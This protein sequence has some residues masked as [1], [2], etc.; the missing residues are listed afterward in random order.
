MILRRHYKQLSYS[1]TPTVQNGLDEGNQSSK[2]G[3]VGRDFLNTYSLLLKMPLELKPDK[4]LSTEWQIPKN[5]SPRGGGRGRTSY[6]A[7]W[8]PNIANLIGITVQYEVSGLINDEHSYLAKWQ[9]NIANL[10]GITVQYEVS[11]L[12][13]D[14]HGRTH[15]ETDTYCFTHSPQPAVAA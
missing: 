6:L 1:F 14:E 15:V 3:G 7:K 9:P 13:N 4:R 12:I 11:G 5:R 8:Q 10:I 2:W